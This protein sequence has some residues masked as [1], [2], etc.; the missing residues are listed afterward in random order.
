MEGRAVSRA[1]RALRDIRALGIG[2][3]LRAAYE[4]SKRIGGH[5]VIFG[6]LVPSTASSSLTHLPFRYR[7]VPDEVAERTLRSAEQIN[8]GTIELFGQK[9]ELAQPPAWH[10]LIH[11]EGSWPR[12]PWWQIDLR[13]DRRPGDVKWAWE[14]G[15]HRHLVILA[16]AAALEPTEDRHHTTLANH[17]ESWLGANPPEIGVHWYSNLELALRSISWLQILSL[18]G[19]RLPTTV[20][21]RMVAHLHHAGRHL[22]ADLPYTVSTMRNNHLLGDGLGLIAL[23]TAFGGRKG[24][25]WKA[26]GNRIF[27]RQLE[28][29][30]CPDGSMIEDS[31]SYHRFVLEMLAMRV[32]LGNAPQS[33]TT[34]MTDAAQFLARLGSLAG[35]I[36]Q[37]GDWDEGRVFAVADGP[38]GVAGSVRLALALAGSGAPPEWRAAHDEVAWFADAGEPVLPDDPE[39]AGNDIGGGIARAAAGPITVWLKGGSNR[40]HGHADLSSLAVNH[41]GGWVIGDPG[42]GTYNGPIEVRNYFRSSVAHSVC[43]VDGLDQLEPHRAFRWVNCASGVVGK[44]IQLEG[45]IVMWSVHDA[46]RRLV[47]TRRVARVVLVHPQGIRVTDRIEGSPVFTELSL[48]APPDSDWDAEDSMLRIGERRYRV[49]A[50]GD[51]SSTKGCPDPYSGW[52]S[53]T[54]GSVAAAPML[55]SSART[56]SFTWS[57]TTAD[58]DVKA[59]NEPIAEFDVVFEA[60]IVHLRVRADRRT[61]LRS[62]AL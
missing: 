34:A 50:S 56:D 53:D 7:P 3:P 5:R 43:R 35:A 8:K 25:R 19:D 16:R 20:T 33:V 58:G 39:L 45:G 36:P 60:E 41:A 55:S 24:D 30:M 49:A 23:G 32:L 2:A 57:I 40:S 37:Y 38:S 51:I 12:D 1:R 21:T 44:P 17:L 14:L 22:L 59:G 42:T 26:V 54:Y 27:D 9:L 28:R 52:W 11:T 47:P 15:R 29:H 18:A 6:R 31:L 61:Y 4:A 13:S 48:P 62:L 10:A 46:Y